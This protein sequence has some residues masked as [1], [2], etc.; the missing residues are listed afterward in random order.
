MPLGIFGLSGTAGLI[1]SLVI[2]FLV[3]V[4]LAL[5]WWTYL[6]ARRRIEDPVLI[7]CATAAS[8]F[9]VFGHGRLH[10]PAPPGVPRGPRGARAG[11]ASRRARAA[12]ADRELLSALRIPDR[13]LLPSLPQLR[14]AAAQPVPQVPQAT[15]SAL[16]HLP[17]LRD[18]GPQA[19][20]PGP[21]DHP[22]H[23]P[24]AI[25][26]RTVHESALIELELGDATLLRLVL[27]ILLILRPPHPSPGPPGGR[28]QAAAAA[29][30]LEPLAP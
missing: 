26:I 19:A 13:T 3:V 27:F 23:R 6:D 20:A 22:S 11:A 7:A 29:E 21:R 18:A 8:V 17:V 12:A 10:D 4:Y 30:Q 28:S 24:A 1:A 14:A 16:G 5:I 25:R 2:L 9:P 15:R